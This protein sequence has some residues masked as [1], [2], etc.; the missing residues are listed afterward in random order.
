MN[1]Y[2]IECMC[3]SCSAQASHDLPPGSTV[4]SI[5]KSTGF[6]SFFCND[7]GVRWICPSCWTRLEP[8]FLVLDAVLGERAAHEPIEYLVLRWRGQREARS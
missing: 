5:A 4:G 7:A 2:T 3:A 6:T 8:A 1:K